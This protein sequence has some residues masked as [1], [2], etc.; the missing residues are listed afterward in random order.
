MLWMQSCVLFAL[1][2]DGSVFIFAAKAGDEGAR[3]DVRE[4]MREREIQ[5]ERERE[6]RGG[7]EAGGA[8]GFTGGKGG[9]GG[10]AKALFLLTGHAQEVCERVLVSVF[11]LLY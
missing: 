9:G 2:A 11:V 6:E 10:G 7:A 3:D 5:R 4:S 1:A 8:G